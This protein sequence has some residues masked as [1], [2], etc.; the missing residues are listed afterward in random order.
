MAIHTPCWGRVCWRWTLQAPNC[1][2]RSG[3][4]CCTGWV[5]DRCSQVRQA[6]VGWGGVECAVVHAP[7]EQRGGEGLHAAWQSY[8]PLTHSL[9]ALPNLLPPPSTSYLCFC[10]ATTPTDEPELPISI[11]RHPLLQEFKLSVFCKMP[12]CSL[13][14]LDDLKYG[15][16]V[17][18]LLSVFSFR[19]NQRCAAQPAV[20]DRLGMCAA[21]GCWRCCKET[22]F[23][24]TSHMYDTHS[25]CVW[26]ARP[27]C[28]CCCGA[29]CGVCTHTHTHT[30]T[31]MF[32]QTHPSPASN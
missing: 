29:S 31:G 19:I 20:T 25:C 21:S 15:F 9:T 5:V 10:I 32:V 23:C 28:L 7:L 1:A 24:A 17:R 14:T 11:F 8:Y 2:T 30:H 3:H 18:A 13:K 22:G 26:P 6:L 16:M 27:C 12:V 4:L